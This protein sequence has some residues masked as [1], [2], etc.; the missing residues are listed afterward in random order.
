[1]NNSLSSIVF[2]VVFAF[3]GVDELKAQKGYVEIQQDSTIT[4]LMT[5]KIEIDTENYASK[6]YTIQL[7]YGD[8]KRAQE[9]YDNFKETFPDWEVNL[10]FETPNYKVQVGRYKDYYSGLNKLNEV[11]RN[12]P[13]AFLLE[14]K[15]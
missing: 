14:I 12:Y 6:F 15:D 7:F 4:K 5:T 10:S 8:N 3:A 9:L 1:M 11:K 2:I 13:A